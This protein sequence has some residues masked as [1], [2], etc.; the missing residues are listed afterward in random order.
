MTIATDDKKTGLKEL[1]MLAS[2]LGASTYPPWVEALV[3]ELDNHSRAQDAN[4]RAVTDA[5]ARVVSLTSQLGTA[6]GD[7]YRAH[8]LIDEDRNT[9]AKLCRVLLDNIE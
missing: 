4:V 6:K 1:G 3:R 7:L 2:R 9:L 5:E 8:Q